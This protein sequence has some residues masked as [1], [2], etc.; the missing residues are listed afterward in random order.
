LEIGEYVMLAISD[1]A[2]GMTD[3]VKTRLFEPFFTT[4]RPWQGT[5][6]ACDCYGIIN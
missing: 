4:K 1:T 3:E 2:W 6:L 5:G